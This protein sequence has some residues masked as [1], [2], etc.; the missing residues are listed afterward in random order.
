MAALTAKFLPRKM[1]RALTARVESPAGSV[2]SKGKLQPLFVEVP[3]KEE[4]EPKS[5]GRRS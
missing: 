5:P 1:R 4:S 2:V 3:E